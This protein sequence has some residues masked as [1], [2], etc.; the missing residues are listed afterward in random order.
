MAYAYLSTLQLT[1]DCIFDNE[2]QWTPVPQSVRKTVG[3]DIVIES[4]HPVSNSGRPL[5]VS[6]S[7]ITKELLNDLVNLR[8]AWTQKA[9][10]LRLCDG[11]EFSVVFNHAGGQ[12]LQVV[13][14]V[15][16]PDY[17]N[18]PSPDDYDVRLNLLEGQISDTNSFTFATFNPADKHASITLSNGDLTATNASDGWHSVRIDMDKNGEG[19]AYAEFTIDVDVDST[20]R[21]NLGVGNSSATLNNYVGSDGNGWGYYGNTGEKVTGGVYT[22]YGDTFTDGDVIQVA[23]DMNAGKVWFGKNGIWVGDP[24]GRTGEAFSGLTGGMYLMA[25][26][27]RIT[28]AMTA[29]FGASPFT[30]HAPTGFLPG[31]LEEA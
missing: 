21:F 16:R 31:V 28:S 2:W 23:L 26:I 22:A 12:P 11:R 3:G 30:Y 5:S 17:Y 25:S 29:N 19:T 24:A 9:Y 15:V 18:V 14:A 4:L 8:G 20:G 7:W 27:Y 10:I 1:E 13:P 6:I